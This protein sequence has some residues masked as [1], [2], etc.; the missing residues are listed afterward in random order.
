MQFPDVVNVEGTTNV[1]LDGFLRGNR[2]DQPRKSEGSILQALNLMNSTVIENRLATAG[3]TPSPLI[4]QNMNKSPVD[5]INALY[6]NILSRYP[7]AGE[8]ARAQASVPAATG[9][10]RTQAVQ[11]LAWSLYNKVDF[12][13]N[14]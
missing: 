12:V 7:S 11:D 8:L 14:Y 3:A 5:L 1:F 6:L 9:T 10:A 13:F 4:I 2:D